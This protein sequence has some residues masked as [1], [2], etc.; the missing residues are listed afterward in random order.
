M[1]G[2]L[3]PRCLLQANPHLLDDEVVRRVL[4]SRCLGINKLIVNVDFEASV[5]GREKDDR[6]DRVLRTYQ[7]LES[8]D[9]CFRQ[10]GGSGR[11]VSRH[12]EFDADAH[13]TSGDDRRCLRLWGL[14]SQ[15]GQ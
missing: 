13:K 8:V 12:A 5:P 11:V 4:A 9:Q 6:F 14:G 1:I 3:G 10:T 15:S 2:P 7:R